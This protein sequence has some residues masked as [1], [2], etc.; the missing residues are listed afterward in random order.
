MGATVPL[1]GP[2]LGLSYGTS[3]PWVFT[4]DRVLLNFLPG[5]AVVLGG[6]GL[7]G[8]ARVVGGAFAGWLAALGGAWFAVGP[9]VSTLWN[10]GQ[11]AAGEP[12]AASV[13]GRAVT[14]LVFHTGLGTLIV[15]LAAVA[16]G[17]FTA[18]TG[19]TVVVPEQS[20]GEY[21]ARH[22][23]DEDVTRDDVYERGARDESERT[24]VLSRDGHLN[25]AD[26]DARRYRGSTADDA[27]RTGPVGADARQD[28]TLGADR[29]GTLN[30]GPRRDGT[31]NA[32]DEV[33]RHTQRR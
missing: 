18:G 29:D 6:L 10:G 21:D 17:R 25:T 16:L 14:E 22:R 8:S 1:F 32:D 11:S 15:F 3:D 12:L 7:M 4:G 9:T 19:R 27:R 28:G 20:R 30:T 31:L 24:H 33:R 26:D 13:A 2:Y 23:A 5:L